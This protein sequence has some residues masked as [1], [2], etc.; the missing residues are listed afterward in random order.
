MAWG[1]PYAEGS[2]TAKVGTEEHEQDRRHDKT[3]EISQLIEVPRQEAQILSC[4]S[5][6][7]RRKESVLTGGGL[8]IDL[9]S[10]R[11]EVSRGHS[12]SG[13]HQRKPLHKEQQDGIVKQHSE[14]REP[15]NGLRKRNAEQRFERGRWHRDG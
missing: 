7:H 14:E 10:M 4:R 15:E 3:D 1:D 13:Q 12:S 11:Q 2:E 9:I 6:R 5:G 8:G